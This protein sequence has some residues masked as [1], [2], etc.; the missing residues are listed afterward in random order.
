MSSS[1]RPA[2]DAPGGPIITEAEVTHLA[3]LAVIALTDAEIAEY[4]T[5]FGQIIAALSGVSQFGRE[6]VA[7]SARATDAVN[8]FREDVVRPGLTQEEALAGAPAADA[9]RFGVPQ[10]LGEEQ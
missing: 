9:G 10:I 7:E 6:D 3:Q 8:V 2:S 1:D 5:E 4:T